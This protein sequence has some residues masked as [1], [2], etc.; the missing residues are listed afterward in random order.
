MT[1]ADVLLEALDN[2]PEETKRKYQEFIGSYRKF[3]PS[4]KAFLKTKEQ[5]DKIERGLKRYE[6]SDSSSNP[7]RIRLR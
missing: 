5:I 1:M 4:Y 7:R 2:V 6:V 3:L